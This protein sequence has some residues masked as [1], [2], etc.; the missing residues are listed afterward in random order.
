M[1]WANAGSGWEHVGVLGAHYLEPVAHIGYMLRTEWWGKGVA[2]KAV[3]LFLEM[4]WKLER[5]EVLLELKGDEHARHLMGLEF[6]QDEVGEDEDGLKIVP[7]IMLAEV[8]QSNVGSIRVVERNGFV[9]KGEESIV[10]D[11]GPFLLK[12]YVL[13]KRC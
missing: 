1:L 4:W 11:A 3:G 7:E 2:S 12:D 5:K 9:C 6:G 13:T 10:E 8:E